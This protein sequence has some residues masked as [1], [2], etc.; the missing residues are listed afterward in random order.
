MLYF[1]IRMGVYLLSRGIFRGGN[2]RCI[3]RSVTLSRAIDV[4]ES[5]SLV[6]NVLVAYVVTQIVK[7]KLMHQVG[8]LSKG[9][10]V[11]G[12]DGV[13]K[14]IDALLLVISEAVE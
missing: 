12:I 1:V 10:F 11:G 3:Y 13:V 14:R 9:C 5:H 8:F 7:E 6:L 2:V 4:A